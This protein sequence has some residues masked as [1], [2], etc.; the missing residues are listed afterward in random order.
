MRLLLWAELVFSIEKSTVS[1]V[2]PLLTEVEVL[3]DAGLQRHQ[4]LHHG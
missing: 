1:V 2:S 3:D 4:E